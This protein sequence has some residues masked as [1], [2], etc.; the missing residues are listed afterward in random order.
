MRYVVWGIKF[1]VFAVVVMFA[2][3]NMGPVE[4]VLFDGLRW[5]EV[6]LIVVILVSFVLGTLLGAMLMLPGTWRRGR[7]T[8]RLRRDLG[9]VRSSAGK[10]GSSASSE[11]TS[12]VTPL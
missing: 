10:S 12:T 8:W 2:Y 3:K 7:E 5:S 11:S 4:V 6:P 9:K 1:L